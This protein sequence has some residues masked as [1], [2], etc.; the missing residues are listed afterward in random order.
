MRWSFSIGRVRG[1]AIRVHGT[2][3]LLVAVAGNRG[4]QVNG[5]SGALEA[6]AVLLALFA[7]VLLHEFGHVAAARRYGVR[8]PEILLLPIGGVAQ[9]ERM[10]D[11]P[12]QELVIALAGPAVTAGLAAAAFGARW[13]VGAE[14]AVGPSDQLLPRVLDELWR[15]NVGLLLF[16]LIPAFPMD[17]GRVLRSLLALRLGLARGTRIAAIVGQGL[18]VLLGAYALTNGRLLLGVV[19]V[20]VFLAAGSEAHA[21]R[22]RTMLDRVTTGMHML[23]GVVTMPAYGTIHDAI[24]LLA[25]AETRAV[26]VVDEDAGLLGLLT[27]DD[28][29][30]ALHDGDVTQPVIG[31]MQIGLP[32]IGSDVPLATAIAVM[33]ASKLGIVPVL[34]AD[35]RPVGLLPLAAFDAVVLP[36]DART[37]GRLPFSSAPDDGR[38]AGN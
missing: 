32:R 37:D 3:L 8:T 23:R 1:T 22:E 26:V 21:V 27:R 13:L 7:C 9:L 35:G 34:D 29:V 31:A 6:I 4:F 38:A 5:A 28:I 12:K 20:F 33:R 16:N 25:G 36:S 14:E 15:V 19:A 11:E 18:A 30:R 17:G 24:G 2:F 10:P